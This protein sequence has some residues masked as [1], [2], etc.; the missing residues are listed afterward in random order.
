MPID[1]RSLT[2]DIM[3]QEGRKPRDTVQA[4]AVIGRGAAVAT[5]AREGE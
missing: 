2:D 3:V 4:A 5:A 1:A